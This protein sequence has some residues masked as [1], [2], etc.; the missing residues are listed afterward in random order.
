MLA[1]DVIEEIAVLIRTGFYDKDRLMEI[2]CEELYEPG[3]LDADEVSAAID[4]QHTEWLS[5]KKGWPARTDCDRLDD[6]F[7]ALEK[8]GII[9]MQNAGYTQSDGY[10]D[11]RE[12]YESHPRKSAIV[13]YC[14][15]HEQD[16]EHALHGDGLFFAFGPVDPKAEETKGPEIGNIVREELERVG[17]T[18]DWDGTF[19]KRLS[20]PKF[21][22]QRR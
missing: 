12:A 16:L 6:A 3:E 9:A 19:A 17:F 21:V 11:F 14:F 22:W 5:E 1:P 7:A 20:V 15:Y 13:G 8:R 10:D 18:V 2:V 4:A